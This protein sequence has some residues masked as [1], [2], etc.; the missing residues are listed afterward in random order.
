MKDEKYLPLTEYLK[1]TEKKELLLSMAEVE[2]ILGFSLD[3]SAFQHKEFWANCTA[4]TKA[5][6]W[7]DAGYEIVEINLKEE[8]ILFKQKAWI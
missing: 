6:S 3:T 1:R 2:E 7:M 8:T 4:S 5:Y